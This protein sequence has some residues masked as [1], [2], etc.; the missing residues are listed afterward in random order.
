MH[1]DVHHIKSSCNILLLL[2]VHIYIFIY[3]YIYIQVW[4]LWHLG[5]QFIGDY[6]LKPLWQIF[7]IGSNVHLPCDNDFLNQFLGDYDFKMRR[8]SIFYEQWQFSPA[9]KLVAILLMMSS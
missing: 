9:V 3:I 4:V 1:M 7:P 5:L 8:I 6:G 2:N